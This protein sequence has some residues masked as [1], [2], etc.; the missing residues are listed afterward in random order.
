MSWKTTPFFM[1]CWGILA[2]SFILTSCSNGEP[3]PS[4]A[5]SPTGTL[6]IV[7]PT[8]AVPTISPSPTSVEEPGTQAPLAVR[9]NGEGISLEVYQTEL[10]LFQDALGTGL[11]TYGEEKVL[12]DLIDQVLLAQAANDLGYQLDEN[13]LDIRIGE[14]GLSSQ[15]LED[16]MMN[17]GF[18]E[19]SF[20]QTMRREI[21][22]AWMRDQL[23]AD[24]PD[25]AEQ[26]HARQILLYNSNEAEAVYAQLEVGMDF[27][28]LANQY[29]PVT[30]GDLGW[31]PRGYLNVTELDDVLF[32]LEP[33]AYSP[34][35]QSPIGYHIVQVL[36]R[37]PDHTLTADARRVLQVQRLTQWL[38]NRRN[39]S[40][41]IILL[42]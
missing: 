35:I 1:I 23:I 42:P 26:V 40:E 24:V 12:E 18:S 32:N 10:A 14:L 11:A 20:R 36:E 8:D 33:G 41:I 3:L 25:T 2:F 17:Y 38:E 4:S 37:E 15:G 22:A 21:A 6:E 29:E 30:S 19:G 27:G 39:Q 16:W 7:D 31:F 13:L 28:T 34:I 9:I 5:H